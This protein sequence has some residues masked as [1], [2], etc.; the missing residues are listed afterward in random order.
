M[1]IL[2]TFR[3]ISPILMNK[4][5]LT[6]DQLKLQTIKYLRESVT[7]GGCPER[8]FRGDFRRGQKQKKVSSYFLC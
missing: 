2:V 6:Y 3:C 5:D 4:Y 1:T 8:D 7:R